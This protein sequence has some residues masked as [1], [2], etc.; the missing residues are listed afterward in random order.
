MKK[1]QILI[2][3]KTKN[4]QEWICNDNILLRFVLNHI[5][6][7]FHKTWCKRNPLPNLEDVKKL[8]K[9]AGKSRMAQKCSLL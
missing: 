2:L 8:K 5:Q 7:L 9:E 6:L 1:K 3:G 4:V